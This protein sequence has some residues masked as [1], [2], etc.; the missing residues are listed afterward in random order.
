MKIGIL[1]LP[2]H[3]NYGGIIQAYALQTVLERMGHEVLVFDKDRTPVRSSWWTNTRYNLR[4]F[5]S[6]V[7]HRTAFKYVNLDAEAKAK[8]ELFLL[9]TQN[10]GRFV[11]KYIH[12]LAVR[13][14]SKDI[15]NS[16]VDAVVVGSD[17]IWSYTYGAYIN[18][19]VANAFLP[20]L[21]GKIKCLSYAASF[22]HEEWKYGQAETEIAKKAVQSFC[23]VSV[24]ELSGVALCRK[25]LDVEAQQHVDPTMLLTS[26]DYVKALHIE[27]VPKS[28][29]N[30]LVYI[31]DPDKEK[32][33]VVSYVGQA[34][35]LEPFYI[36]SKAEAR[37]DKSIRLEE[38]IQPPVEQWLRGFFDA[39]YVVTDSFHACVFSILFHKP[40]V[41]VGNK[42]RGLSRFQSLLG[43]FGIT[44]R[45]VDS[46]SD[47][48]QKGLETPI[49]YRAIDSILDK[50]RERSMEFLRH[51]LA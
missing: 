6:C 35:S 8:Y 16:G 2:L 9:K 22:G 15:E 26:E 51:N 39:D 48:K 43:Q 42:E 20:S 49:D 37:N 29:G 11:D 5:L 18:G 41:V 31:L 7:L 3:T 44:D 25:Y 17:Q 47:V 4:A 12:T 13:Q 1:T 33:A 38:R 34:L 19:S 40:F 27:S 36:N 45:L 46:L 30:L 28:P 10:T 50:E 14:Y 32:Q 21:V 23:G 24:R